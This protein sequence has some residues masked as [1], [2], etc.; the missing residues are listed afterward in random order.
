MVRFSPTPPEVGCFPI[1]IILGQ[2]YDVIVTAD[3]SHVAKNFWMRS[4]PC[5]DQSYSDNFKGIVYYGDS[6]NTP[7]TTNFTIPEDCGDETDN[8]S[9]IVKKNVS[10]HPKWSK[11]GNV[12]IQGETGG[13]QKWAVN[14]VSMQVDWQDPSLM[15]AYKK[16]SNWSSVAGVIE[17]DE[18]ND[19]AYILVESSLN[20]PHPIHLHGHDFFVLAQGEGAFESSDIDSLSNPPR[21]D[22]AMLFGKGYLLLAFQTDNPG[23]WLMHCHIGW[24]TSGGLAVQFIERY[25]EIRGIIDDYASM[26]STCDNW[27]RWQN[28]PDIDSGI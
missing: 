28:F 9:P 2:R 10:A 13:I 18:A 23:A 20:V 12:A 5:T 24:H 11:T 16:E 8:L 14:D 15:Q 19:W 25:S 3:Q 21:R 26:K 7:S 17:L 22:T 1:L 4:V 6:P 27:D